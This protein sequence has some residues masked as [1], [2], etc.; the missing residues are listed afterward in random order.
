MKAGLK[1]ILKNNEGNTSEIR[2]ICM[3]SSI[4]LV[5]KMRNIF[6]NEPEMRTSKIYTLLQ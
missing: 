6:F 2:F 1:I 4:N 3:E 5:V